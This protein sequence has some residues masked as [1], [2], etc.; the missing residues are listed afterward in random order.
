M[1][2]DRPPPPPRRSRTE[3]DP[4]PRPQGQP[5][6]DAPPEQR[7]PIDPMG[8][9][10]RLSL[11]DKDGHALIGPA[12]AP[13]GSIQDIMLDTTKVGT[14]RLAPL[15]QISNASGMDFVTLQIRHT[16][17]LAIA[18]IF[19]AVAFS[20]WLAR[21]LLRPLKSLHSVTA[22]VSKGQ[23][24]ARAEVI[25]QDELGDLAQDIN[26]MA[27]TLEK[28]EKQRSK[29]LADVSHELRTPLTVILGEIEALL[30]G[31]RPTTPAAL[32]SLHA[33]V[34]HLNKLVDD[35]RQLTLAD[36]GD[37]HYNFE[38]IDLLALLRELLLRF[39][40]RIS[41][42]DLQLQCEL[43]DTPL[44][45]RADSGRM[46]QVI[47]NL[48]EN[49]VRYTDAG[50]KLVCRLTR[51]GALAELSMED[52]A[53]GVPAGAHALL[54]DRLYRVDGARSRE[55]GGSG[56]GLSICK[57]FIEAHQGRICALPS[58]LGG[59]KVLIQ[60]PCVSGPAE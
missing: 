28:N 21:H 18:L 54:F 4:P 60:L 44:W 38:T 31:V 49:S 50:G 17:W 12:D 55:S 29:M 11:I 42:A 59:I 57:I 52:S 33:E 6:R 8:F 46:T 41:Q 16:L 9:G 19:I 48:L 2:G 23:F 22:R 39:Q 53:P 20:L 45:I 56:L 14:L 10:Q 26:A 13:G 27:E 7:P 1:Q 34:I 32:E 58:E 47:S 40:L 36:A 15:R 35:I 25:T 24:Q 43:P 37:L 5:P 51:N 3:Q 30:D